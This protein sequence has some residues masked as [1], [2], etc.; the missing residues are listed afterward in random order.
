MPLRKVRSVMAED[1][2]SIP[3]GLELPR[4]RFLG[5]ASSGLV[6]M[7]VGI[8]SPVSAAGRAPERDPLS[9]PERSVLVESWLGRTPRPGELPDER[10]EAP[11]ELLGDVGSGDGDGLRASFWIT[12]AVSGVWRFGVSSTNRAELMMSPE[13]GEL[14]L[15]GFVQSGAEQWADYVPGSQWG[16]PRRVVEGER[17]LVELRA[18]ALVSGDHVVLMARDVERQLPEWA[19]VGSMV[20]AEPLSSGWVDAVE[21]D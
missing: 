16:E 6:A 17:I 14:S 12:T 19:V 10:V 4:R 13:G 18:S 15:V 2:W 8:K 5:V 21:G 7:S 20:P 9:E 1:H 11:Y 3:G